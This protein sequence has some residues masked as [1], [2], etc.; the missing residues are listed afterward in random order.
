MNVMKLVAVPKIHNCLNHVCKPCPSGCTHGCDNTGRCYQCNGTQGCSNGTHYCVN[1]KC[2][3]CPTNCRFGCD[4]TGRCY[5]C[6]SSFDCG[7]K[8]FCNRNNNR[9]ISCSLNSVRFCRGYGFFNTCRFY[10]GICE[11]GCCIING[12]PVY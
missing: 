2:E 9:C 4:N 1:H 5:E 3:R 7:S 8:R 11:N 12:Y 10:G 6:R